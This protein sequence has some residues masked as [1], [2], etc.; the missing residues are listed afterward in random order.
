MRARV[1]AYLDRQT[2]PLDSFEFYR[3]QR[4]QGPLRRITDA[5]QRSLPV[6]VA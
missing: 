5:L 3:S 4:A 1:L 2:E 6:E